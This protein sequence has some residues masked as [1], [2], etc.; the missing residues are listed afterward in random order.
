MPTA[1]N[2]CIVPSP[3][4]SHFWKSPCHSDWAL[5]YESHLNFLCTTSTNQLLHP[6]W[7]QHQ[8]MKA[9]FFFLPPPP[10]YGLPLFLPKTQSG[11]SV[12]AE[13]SPAMLPRCPTW[14]TDI[15]LSAEPDGNRRCEGGDVA[16][17]PWAQWLHASVSIA[18][19]LHCHLVDSGWHCTR[20]HDYT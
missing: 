3:L 16:N 9:F 14:Q 8:F 13:Q 7:P 10:H 2:V 19:V 4:P 11:L 15:L 5:A 12:R 20:W 1:S 18:T 17:S 6:F